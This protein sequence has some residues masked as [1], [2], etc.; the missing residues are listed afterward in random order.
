MNVGIVLVHAHCNYICHVEN[1]QLS[2]ESCS[3]C[4]AGVLLAVL[5]QPSTDWRLMTA[6]KRKKKKKH[7]LIIISSWWVKWRSALQVT[8]DPVLFTLHTS[9]SI[10][11]SALQSLMRR[12]V[13]ST[14]IP[15]YRPL[16]WIEKIT[17]TGK[18]PIPERPLCIYYEYHNSAPPLFLPSIFSTH[19]LQHRRS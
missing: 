17:A 12:H 11:K 16:M 10:G 9:N 5:K 8:F 7:L 19:P 1:S 4:S 2:A 6:K 15:N 13:C 3:V 18:S 14:F